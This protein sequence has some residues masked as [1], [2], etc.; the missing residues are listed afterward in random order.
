MYPHQAER[1]TAA[2]EGA[3][4]EALVATAPENVAYVTGFASV[5]N[6]IFATPQF[7]VYARRGTALVVPAIEVAAIVADAL[8]VGHVVAFGGFQ[9]S[10]ADPAPAAVRRIASIMERRA[11]SPADGVAAALEALDVRRGPIGLDE[12]RLTADAWRQLTERLG[13]LA[14]VPAASHLGAARRVK[15]PYEIEC[16]Q[17]A[18]AIAEEA[19]NAVVQTLE[20]G[21]TERE[22]VTAY[23]TEVLRRGGQ[24]SAAVV[25]MGE[26]SWVPAP[27]PSDRAL[28]PGDLVRLDVGAVFKGYHSSVARTAVMGAPR[29]RQRMAI[30]ALQSGL[31]AAIDAVRPGTPA[32]RVFGAAVEAVRAAGLADYRHAHVGHG[33]GLAPY[34]RPKLAGGDPTALEAGEVLRIELPYYEFGWAGPAV[35][36]TVLVTRGGAAVLNRSH[37]GLLVLD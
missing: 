9:A 22:A 26:R 29:G 32:G 27:V 7:A 34:E 21:V 2:L 12:Q 37:R 36:D 3:G 23:Q 14:V 24:P 16:L 15:S 13:P 20:P 1:L 4:L 30:D 6:A 28:R 33:I 35:R 19:L 11:A 31:E 5:T 8:D 18:L 17:R 25:A 10:V